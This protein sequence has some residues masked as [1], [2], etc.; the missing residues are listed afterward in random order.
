MVK[1]GNGLGWTMLGSYPSRDTRFF[2]SGE[3]QTGA[4][5]SGV[6]RG[7]FGGV[8]IPPEIPKALQN[9]AK[10]SP[11]MKNGKNC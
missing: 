10:L 6:P 4:G 5:A 11:I 7:G 2:F 8:Q 9:R 3:H 1:T